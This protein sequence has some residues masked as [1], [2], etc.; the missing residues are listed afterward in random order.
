M[1]AKGAEC[2][3]SHPTPNSLVVRATS[4]RVRQQHL[5]SIPADK[6]GKCL[7]LLG[8]KVFSSSSLQVRIASYQVPLAKDNFLN[9]TKFVEFTDSFPQQ[10]RAHFQAL[11]NEGKLISRTTLQS[12]VNAADVSSS[13]MA[14]AI[15]MCK[16]SWLH[17]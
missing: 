4:E 9:Y 2:L 15:I 11:I 12:A 6:E 14:I 8:R 7:D 3:F 1:P 5:W 16:E 13:I 10:D 17:A